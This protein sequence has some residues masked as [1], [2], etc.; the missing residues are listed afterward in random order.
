VHHD[1]RLL[2]A[3]GVVERAKVGFERLI[4]NYRNP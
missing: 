2:R 3:P 1:A 4:E